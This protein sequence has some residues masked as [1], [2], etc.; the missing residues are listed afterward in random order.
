MG[1][2]R[3]WRFVGQGGH[4]DP[5]CLQRDPRDVSGHK[6]HGRCPTAFPLGGFGH[7]SFGKQH[8]F[9]KTRSF[10]RKDAAIFRAPWFCLGPEKVKEHRGIEDALDRLGAPLLA[11][12]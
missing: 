9:P 6:G 5:E 12:R 2:L 3:A 1:I 7:V 11:K 10:L 4:A 8:G